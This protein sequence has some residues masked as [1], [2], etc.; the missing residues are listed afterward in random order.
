MGGGLSIESRPALDDRARYV[1]RCRLGRGGSGRVETTVLGNTDHWF[2]MNIDSVV[3]VV[4]I[5]VV[6]A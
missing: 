6:H 3:C 2:V 1:E 4:F 5:F